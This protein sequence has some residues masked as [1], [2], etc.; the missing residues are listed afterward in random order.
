M[1]RI[2]CCLAVRVLCVGNMYPP[3]DLRGG[4]ELTW[5]SSVLHLAD[6]GHEVRVLTTDFRSPGLDPADELDPEVYRELHWYWRDHEFPRLSAR[7]R[8]AIERHNAATFD[9]HVAAFGPNVVAWWG[10][11]GMSLS[12]VE[13][14]RRAGLPAVGIV[15]DEWLRWG[16]RADGWLRPLHRVP[17]LPRLAEWLL[18][19][20]A[21]VD[22]DAAAMWLFNS[23]TVREK[24]RASGLALP[25]SQVVHPGIDD[26]LF[27]AAERQ[28]WQW[29][30]LYLGRLDPRKGIDVA[31][32]ALALLPNEAT[33]TIQGSGG[34]DDY[35]RALRLRAHRLG[36]A[37]RV[38][39]S[40]LERSRLPGLVADADVLLFPVQWDEP[41]G[42]VP[43]EAMA[44]GTPVV[45]TGTGGSREYLDNE[46]NCLIYAP[47]ESAEELAAAIRRLGDQEALRDRLRSGGFETSSRYTETAYND[48]ILGAL[49]T[50]ASWR[51]SV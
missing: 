28:P 4:Y 21:D 8:V 23:E 13:Q 41:W 11:G 1:A 26:S 30:L 51:E 50:A 22:L 31:V 19:L 27:V 6:R 48:A 2:V 32:D 18:G 49:D 10:M 34:A 39:F 7:E 14:A 3:H 46:R 35:A 42:L 38:T 43:L 36:L 29:R 37:D 45:A 33:L 47:K 12:L 44:V 24:T 40:A 25:R 17:G 16:P 9:R 5:R 15:G 20:P